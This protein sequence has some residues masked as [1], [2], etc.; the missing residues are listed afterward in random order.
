[1]KAVVFLIKLWGETEIW[2]FFTPKK[3]G[4]RGLPTQM[5]LGTTLVSTPSRGT[6]ILS[7]PSFSIVWIHSS[8]VFPRQWI[9]RYHILSLCN[10][11]PFISFK[12]IFQL[13]GYS[14]ILR[15]EEWNSVIYFHYIT[16]VYILFVMSPIIMP[17]LRW[18]ISYI[19]FFLSS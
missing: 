6:S 5:R 15:Q 3:G 13:N 12:L 18:I 11:F 7:A 17:F 16:L 2:R 19:I 4:K 8:S 14:C 1:M 10:T 9:Q